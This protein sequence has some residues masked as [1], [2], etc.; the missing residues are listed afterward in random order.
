M[1][2]IRK[3]DS[4]NKHEIIRELKEISN[5]VCSDCAEWDIC[6]SSWENMQKCWKYRLVNVV[7]KMVNN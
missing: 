4:M 7:R 5:L 3:S 2:N 6:K 1:L